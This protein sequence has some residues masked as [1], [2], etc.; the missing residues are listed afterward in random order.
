M[1][2][3]FRPAAETEKRA[4]EQLFED[5]DAP[6]ARRMGLQIMSADPHWLERAIAGGRVYAGF[7]DGQLVGAALTRLK[8][9]TIL[10]I[11]HVAVRPDCQGRGVGGWMLSC[12]E[13]AARND[14]CLKMSFMTAAMMSEL[15]HLGSR[16]GFHETH[17]MLTTESGKPHV[18]VYMEKVL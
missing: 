4:V 11:D 9:D 3:L 10:H 5:A 13:A 14:K 17:R 15:L 16:F 6:E 1:E 8:D 18:Q 2:L 7:V 12:I